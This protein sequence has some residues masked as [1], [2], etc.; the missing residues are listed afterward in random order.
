MKTKILLT[1]F[2]ILII[3]LLVWNIEGYSH[4]GRT[5]GNGCHTDHSKGDY[6]CHNGTTNSSTRSRTQII[7]KYKDVDNNF[8]ND[9]EQ[10]QEEL[11]NNI[12][13]IGEGEG[14]LGA[15]AGNYNPKAKINVFTRVE[16]SSYKIGYD[17]GYQKKKIE[18]QKDKAKKIGNELGEK[19]STYTIPIKYSNS[20]IQKSFEDGFINAQSHKWCQ[21]TKEKA[22]KN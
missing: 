1:L 2:P 9:Y 7:H 6:H 21:F 17:N 20:E 11:L 4:S 5:D 12:M 18:M 19:S 3:A 22:I 8:Q 14:L 16:Y 15:I 13:M 10:N